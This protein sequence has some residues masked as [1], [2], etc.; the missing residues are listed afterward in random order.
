LGYAG[1]DETPPS[2]RVTNTLS[3][4]MRIKRKNA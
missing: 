4:A 1:C 3:G 2:P